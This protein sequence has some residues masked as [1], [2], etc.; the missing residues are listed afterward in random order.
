M[1]VIELTNLVVAFWRAKFVGAR[2]LAVRAVGS[3]QR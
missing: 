1:K 2:Y 3:P